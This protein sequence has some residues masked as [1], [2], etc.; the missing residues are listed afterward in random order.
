MSNNYFTFK[1]FTIIQEKSVFKVGT[2][3]VLLGACAALSGAKRILDVGTGTGLIAIMAAQRSDAEIVA[4]E[5]DENSYKEACNNVNNTKWHK[6]IIV[7]NIGFQKYFSGRTEK[8]DIIITNPPYF[9]D[10]LKNPDT[11]KSEARHSDSLTSSE[12]LDGANNLLNPGGSL[13]LILPYTEGTL[14]IAEASQYGFFCNHIIKIKAIPA[15][16]IKRLILKFERVRKPA[17]EKFLT[18]ETG[19]RHRYTEEYKEFTREFYLKF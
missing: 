10:S 14:F 5:P 16:D 12:I 8:F 6:R 4:I 13:Q 17:S 19:T 11:V 2:D 7:Q 18:I 3:G 15:G 1:Q 9:S